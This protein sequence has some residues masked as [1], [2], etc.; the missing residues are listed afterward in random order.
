MISVV[1]PTLNAGKHLPQ[2][3]SQLRG[4]V[5][6]IIISDGVSSDDSLYIAFGY[7]TRIAI[8]CKG[9]GWQLA[10]GAKWASLGHN[11]ND[12]L[13]FLHADAMLG[14]GWINAV[15]AHIENH[16]EKAG[17]FTFKV[18]DKGWRPR[19]MEM[20][21]SMRCRF[22]QLPYGDQGLLVSRALY[23]NV[24]GYEN[25]VLFED[26][27]MAESLKGKLTGLNADIYTNA[28]KYKRDG[29]WGR[30][31]ANFR[32]YRRYKKGA[33]PEQLASEYNA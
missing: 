31:L 2:L 23:E 7:K 4:R 6:D 9:R 15:S 29:Y 3:L 30:S 21:V 11:N 28:D 33:R 8:G 13:L 26:V 5:D 19:L 16:P 12:W 10:R 14:S 17:Y 25:W 24:G 32:L 1:I 27:K 20:I 18:K 22:L